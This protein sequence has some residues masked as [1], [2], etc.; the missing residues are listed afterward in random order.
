MPDKAYDQIP[1]LVKKYAKTNL[2]IA[3]SIFLFLLFFQPFSIDN[4]NFENRL[5]YVSGFGVIVF[6]SLNLT[7]VLFYRFYHHISHKKYEDTYTYYLANFTLVMLTTPG[8]IF[9]IRY[10]GKIEITFYIAIKA[11]IIC[12]S[13][14]VILYVVK[15]V[16]LLKEKN[17]LLISELKLLHEKHDQLNDHYSNQFIELLAENS[18]DNFR[19]QIANILYLKSADNYVE[20][21][22]LEGNDFK[23]KLIRNALK[24]IEQQLKEYE[25][26]V[27]THRAGIVNIQHI[28]KLNKTYNTYWISFSETQETVPVARQYLMSVKDL[29]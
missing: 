12:V 5:L 7:L 1:A 20:V 19:I 10:V 13:L 21:G 28:E 26:F 3:F 24:N 6:L 25:G 2:G 15:T 23:K 9:Y 11:V 29:L 8:F 22:Y 4:F 18:S 16:Q 14:V 27:R 17:Q